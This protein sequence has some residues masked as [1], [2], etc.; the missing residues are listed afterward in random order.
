MRRIRA[1]SR[2]T[3]VPL[4]IAGALLAQPI[5]LLA[6]GSLT[7][8]ASGSPAFAVTLNGT[9]QTKTST[10][11]TL[12]AADTRGTGAGWN[13]TITSTTFKAGAH[14]LSTSATAVTGVA[15]S[16]PGGGCTNPTNAIAYPLTVP[17]G[18]VAP[19]AVKLFD[20]KAATG[21]G[22]FTLTPTF[23]IAVPA[24]TYTGSYTSTVTFSIVSGP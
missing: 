17:A 1:V 4:L 8:T 20:A 12:S 7:E 22:T 3:L 11:L 6:A 16:C 21:L 10:A 2:V 15:F 19:A 5:G 23:S 18:A 14:T 24:N 13:V 9:N